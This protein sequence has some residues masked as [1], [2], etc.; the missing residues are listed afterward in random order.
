MQVIA[1][2]D[3]QFHLPTLAEQKESASDSEAS[4]SGSPQEIVINT[5]TAPADALCVDATGFVCAA[6]AA[7]MILVI[8]LITIV[9]LWLRIRSLTAKKGENILQ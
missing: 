3:V 7:I 8:A 5:N 4:E 2:N 9:F 1:P 6:V